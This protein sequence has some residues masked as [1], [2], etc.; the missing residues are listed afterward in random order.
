MSEFALVL[1]GQRATL[2]EAYGHEIDLGDR[3]MTWCDHAAIR[4][5]KV[6]R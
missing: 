3:S 2:A 1:Q 4:L 6:P 5:K